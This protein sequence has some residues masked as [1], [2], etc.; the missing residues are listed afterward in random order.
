MLCSY[1]LFAVD[2]L[3]KVKQID[4]SLGLPIEKGFYAIGFVL[5]EFSGYFNDFI[6]L[7]RN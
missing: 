2:N 1:I 5:H 7:Q 3:L 4:D 6:E